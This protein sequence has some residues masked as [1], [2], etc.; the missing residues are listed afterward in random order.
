MVKFSAQ[1][2]VCDFGALIATGV[3]GWFAF[4]FYAPLVAGIW[5][6][7]SGGISRSEIQQAFAS[8]HWQAYA[9]AAFCV[10]MWAACAVGLRYCWK[11][12][13]F[14]TIDRSGEWV[15]RN[16]LYCALQ[17][18][19]PDEPRQIRARLKTWFDDENNETVTSGEFWVVS[20]CGHPIAFPYSGSALPGGRSAL[21]Q[22][23]GYPAAFTPTTDPDGDLVTPLHTWTAAGPHGAT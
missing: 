20:R 3:V 14:L 18:L 21:W 19:R 23:L 4:L 10:M 17:R 16:A 7:A 13:A 11:R 5:Q 2:K 8:P 6:A 1:V 22:D 9:L 12:P 15:I